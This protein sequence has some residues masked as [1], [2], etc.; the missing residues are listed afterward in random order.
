MSSI[1]QIIDRQVK[2]WEMERER[3]KEA[4]EE[5]VPAPPPTITISRQYGGGGTSLAQILAIRLDYQVFDREVVDA[6]AGNAHFRE[7][8]LETLDEGTLSRIHLWVEA[9]IR[10]R[11]YDESDYHTHLMN[12]LMAIAGHG[13]AI[14]IGRGA[15]FVL[16]DETSLKIR[17]VGSMEWRVARVMEREGMGEEEAR[18]KIQVVDRERSAFVQRHFGRDISDPAGYDAV[19]NTSVMSMQDIADLVQ[20]TLQAKLDSSAG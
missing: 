12:V 4:A 9:L 16:E 2:L 18:R 19:F 7:A 13:K 3:R 15:N 8:T 1:E 5:E 10:G 20:R 14:I 6:I 11:Y 17:L